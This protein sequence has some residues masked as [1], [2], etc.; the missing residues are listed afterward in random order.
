MYSF[1]KIVQIL[2]EYSILIAFI[3]H[4]RCIWQKIVSKSGEKRIRRNS[5][6]T[7]HSLPTTQSDIPQPQMGLVRQTTVPH[8][9]NVSASVCLCHVMCTNIALNVVC[10]FQAK[11]FDFSCKNIPARNT[12]LCW[13]F[14][15]TAE[16][17]QVRACAC[18]TGA[19]PVHVLRGAVA[20]GAWAA[21]L[22]RERD[23]DQRVGAL[24]ELATAAALLRLA[25]FI[26]IIIISSSHRCGVK[27]GRGT[28]LTGTLGG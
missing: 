19:R 12:C 9:F 25:A 5:L 24:Q 11:V 10:F 8:G 18:V 13:C 15:H 27:F 1:F 16:G 6:T 20:E 23:R 2:G 17:K 14:T 26:F 21:T 28:K 3:K 22:D 4:V 7:L